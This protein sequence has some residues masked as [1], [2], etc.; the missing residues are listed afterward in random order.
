MKRTYS[1]ALLTSLL[2]ISTPAMNQI[3]DQPVTLYPVTLMGNHYDDGDSFTIKT[4]HQELTVRLY[5]VDCLEIRSGSKNEL[6]RI[7]EQQH[8]FGLADIKSVIHFGRQAKEFS[9]SALSKPFTVY[10]HYA[11][12]LGRKK[13]VY[14]FVKT[15]DGEYLSEK[16]VAAGLARIHGKTRTNPDGRPSQETVKWLHTIQDTALLNR[17]GIWQK[18]DPTKLMA[19]REQQQHEEQQFNRQ[20]KDLSELPK[21]KKIDINTASS[22]TLQLIKGIGPVRAERIITGRPYKSLDELQRIY[23][24]GTKTLEKIKPYLMIKP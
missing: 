21:G 12:A 13:R 20:I 7:K 24:I 15:A 16:L 17:A 8:H 9:K 19:M 18:T 2:L 22:E 14:A 1:I 5:F 11:D 6:D 23:G 10:T 3:N 4:S